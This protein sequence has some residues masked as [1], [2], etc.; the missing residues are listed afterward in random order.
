MVSSTN[1]SHSPC[2]RGV[3]FGSPWPD[4]AGTEH[5]SDSGLT[6]DVSAATPISTHQAGDPPAVAVVSH[7]RAPEAPP[8]ATPTSALTPALAP[9]EGSAKS[10][11]RSPRHEHKNSDLSDYSAAKLRGLIPPQVKLDIWKSLRPLATPTLASKL[12]KSPVD[13]NSGRAIGSMDTTPCRYS[14]AGQKGVVGVVLRTDKLASLPP[15]FTDE[16]LKRKEMIKSRLQ[17]KSECSSMV[18]LVWQE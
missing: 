5:S 9:G 12:Q 11:S 6:S 18:L 4:R 1:P 16:L 17:F 13:S 15:L 14:S 8:I 7:P 2:G 3:V 10:S